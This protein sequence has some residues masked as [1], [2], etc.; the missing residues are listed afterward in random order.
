MFTLCKVSVCQYK[1]AAHVYRDWAHHR[2]W[3]SC[4]VMA[5]LWLWLPPALWSTLRHCSICPCNA[6]PRPAHH[7]G[8]EGTGQFLWC[9]F[10]CWPG[11]MMQHRHIGERWYFFWHLSLPT[12]CK[13]RVFLW[14]IFD[15]GHG[16][17]Q[18]WTFRSSPSFIIKCHLY[19]A[20]WSHQSHHGI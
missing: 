10:V 13:I 11:K 20:T 8:P 12:A 15:E 7:H 9:A 19:N 6:V 1:S 3:V 5:S 2:A 4:L 16:D 18:H 17:N 14:V